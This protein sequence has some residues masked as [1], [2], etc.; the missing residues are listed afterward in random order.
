MLLVPASSPS[1]AAQYHPPT[2]SNR[3]PP[4]PTR[5]PLPNHQLLHYSFTKTEPPWLSF[6]FFIQI[7]PPS[8]AARLSHPCHA[9]SHSPAP[10]YLSRRINTICHA[11]LAKTEPPRLG[12]RFSPKSLP[13]HALLDRTHTPPQTRFTP[14]QICFPNLNTM[15]PAFR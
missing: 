12:F 5:S 15:P 14:A 1:C 3:V 11:S 6:Q 8:R 2:A 10:I 9:N 4:A 7:S 13:P